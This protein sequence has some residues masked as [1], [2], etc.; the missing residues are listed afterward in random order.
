[1][2]EFCGAELDRANCGG[3]LSGSMIWVRR[4]FVLVPIVVFLATAL[5]LSCGGG[6]GGSTPTGNGN[7]FSVMSLSICPG[8]ITSPTPTPKPTKYTCVT[9]TPLKETP[10]CAPFNTP[11]ALVL[12]TATA[13]PAGTITATPTNL[14]QINVQQTLQQNGNTKKFYGDVTSNGSLSWNVDHPELIALPAGPPFPAG[15]FVALGQGCV[16]ITAQ[17]GNIVSCPVAVAIATLC[18]TPDYFCPTPGPDANGQVCPGP[19]ATPTKTPKPK[20]T[21]TP[22]PTATPT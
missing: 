17:I 4:S 11:I 8:F 13:T 15:Q 19:T 20:P 7:P 16:C 18:A 2:I 22:T 5:L 1:M 9:P 3:H 21:C 14:L 12:D 6:G 10:Q